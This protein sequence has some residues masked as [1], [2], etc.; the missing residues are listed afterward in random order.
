MNVLLPQKFGLSI[1][2]TKH[3]PKS[4]ARLTPLN[5]TQGAAPS[6]GKVSL[7]PREPNMPQQTATNVIFPH[8]NAGKSLQM[9][10]LAY[11][12]CGCLSVEGLGQRMKD[13]GKGRM[14]P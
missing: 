8:Q 7:V 2:H 9:H 6:A 14:L 13:A 12:F 5:L 1:P 10:H 4:R 11:H 3:L